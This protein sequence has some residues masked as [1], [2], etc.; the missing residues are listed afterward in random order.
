MDPVVDKVRKLIRLSVGNNREHESSSAARMAC[1]IIQE[2]ELIILTKEEYAQLG[3]GGRPETTFGQDNLEDFLRNMGVRVH[4]EPPYRR[5]S[6]PTRRNPFR[7][8]YQ[9]RG[10]E[11]RYNP[12]PWDEPPPR[13]EPKGPI[14]RQC[15]VCMTAYDFAEQ[16]MFEDCC[17]T[18]RD[19]L[20]KVPNK[21]SKLK[22]VMHF[23]GTTKI[24]NPHVAE[25]FELGAPCAICTGQI[26]SGNLVVRWQKMVAHR[27]CVL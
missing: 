18:C 3:R 7:D 8:Y 13:S 25:K 19:W 14:F 24:I 1:K 16:R 10:P 15:K 9:Q 6:N 11:P 17:Q 26:V 5:A 12:P 20:L 23:G 4:H 27:G 22:F 2:K 21:E